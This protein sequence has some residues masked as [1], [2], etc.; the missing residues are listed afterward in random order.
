MLRN[1][2]LLCHFLLFSVAWAL[3][4]LGEAPTT[5]P[6]TE[7][8]NL[9]VQVVD[10]D[11]Q[12]IAGASVFVQPLF[13]NEPS[14]GLGANE[15]GEAR[16]SVRPGFR[17]RVKIS[18]ALQQPYLGQVEVTIDEHD[19]KPIRLLGEKAPAV[20]GRAVDA[21]TGQP[22]QGV[23][24]AALRE[25]D[26][27]WGH[28]QSARESDAEGRFTLQLLSPAGNYRF[29][30]HDMQY[31]SD[32]VTR[33]VP[34]ARDEDL[35]VKLQPRRPVV[36]GRIVERDDPAAIVD[37][38]GRLN[39]QLPTIN[40]RLPVTGGRFEIS[41][42]IPPGEYPIQMAA[43]EP[44]GL[45]LS[46]PVLV[47]AKDAKTV[48]VLVEPTPVIDIRIS[49]TDA[50]RQPVSKATVRLLKDSPVASAMTDETG[51]ATLRCRPG[52]YGLVV[53]H[54]D[55]LPERQR[56]DVQA[57]TK[58]IPV[59]LHVGEVIEGRVVGRD[60]ARVDGAMLSILTES[61]QS[62]SVTL[63]AGGHF[64]I[65]GLAPGKA[66]MWLIRDGAAMNVWQAVISRDAD[67]LELVVV[68]GFHVDIRVP[69]FEPGAKILFMDAATGIPVNSLDPSGRENG[70]V[71]LVPSEYAIVEVDGFRARSRGTIKVTQESR[72][73]QLEPPG[74]WEKA[75][76]LLNR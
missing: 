42:N 24:I 3:I 34:L 68:D 50:Q 67:S 43:L 36:P 75:D 4:C 57:S 5:S 25:L 26:G 76:K 60:D 9:L 69:E 58:Q 46:N 30:A 35:I 62:R 66:V 54:P 52:Q 63:D 1:R 10:S 15:Q 39:L 27:G 40:W 32:E 23:T 71:L 7:P 64:R 17:Y 29:F 31:T 56:V 53:E 47:I 11:G 22:V 72:K 12:G 37:I 6:S 61:E 16:V 51:S 33:A 74:E 18:P 49:V 44:L 59:R 65:E 45:Q 21:E 55:F 70:Q 48:E 41:D 73:F 28:M 20:Q 38:D 2:F 14:Q 13:P 8:V 19:P